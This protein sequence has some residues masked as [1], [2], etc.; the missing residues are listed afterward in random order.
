MFCQ[1]G[2]GALCWDFC[3]NVSILKHFLVLSFCLWI[4]GHIKAGADGAEAP[5][6]PVK[7]RPTGSRRIKK[8]RRGFFCS[9]HFLEDFFPWIG[10]LKKSSPRPPRTL[11][12]PCLNIK[13]ILIILPEQGRMQSQ[14][15]WQ[16]HIKIFQFRNGLVVRN[17]QQNVNIYKTYIA[18]I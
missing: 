6:P 10:P 1:P 13:A 3:I 12:R 17:L 4:Q 7:N 8:G 9:S 14:R 11:I 18:Y 16:T 5:G 2:K 15:F